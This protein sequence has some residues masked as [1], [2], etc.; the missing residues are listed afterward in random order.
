ML[1]Y[2]LMAESM[3]MSK[4]PAL[5]K[6]DPEMQRWC[7]VL[8]DEI[9]TWPH[10][11]SRPM[12]GMIGF[13]RGESIFAALPRTRAAETPFSFLV[14]LPF[15]EAQGRPQTRGDRLN[16]ASRPGAGWVTFAMESEGDIAEA[17]RWLERAYGKAV[18]RRSGQVLGQGS[19][20]A[21][22]RGSGQAKERLARARKTR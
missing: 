15:D 18:R 17:L 1:E 19:G 9:S 10:V 2:P 3:K 7:A 22:R 6:A 14:K 8:E 16:K 13:Y 21:L 4:R 11:T 5:P 12:F 20:R